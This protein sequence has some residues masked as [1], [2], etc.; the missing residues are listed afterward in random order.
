LAR[1]RACSAFPLPLGLQVDQF[2]GDIPWAP[3]AF[4]Q[5]VHQP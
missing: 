4:L 5:L 1:S 2:A 3:Q